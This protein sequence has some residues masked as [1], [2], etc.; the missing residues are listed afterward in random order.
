MVVMVSVKV[1]VPA[2]HPLATPIGEFLSDLA[3]AG[4]S[5]H[6]V[7]CYRGDLAQFA[8]HQAV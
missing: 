4:R 2:D 3:G 7:R 5:A 8:A 1:E 6:T